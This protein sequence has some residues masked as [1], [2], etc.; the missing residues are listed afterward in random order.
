MEELTWRCKAF[1]D[2]TQDELYAILKLRS[3]VF[4]VEQECAYLD[5]DGDDQAAWHVLGEAE[6]NLL[7]Y[8]RLLPPGLKYDCCSIGRVVTSSKIRR[9]GIGR[10]LMERSI[11][12]CRQQWPDQ[13][14]TI[15]AQQYLEHFYQSLHFVTESDAYLEDGIPHVRMHLPYSPT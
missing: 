15:S 13:G 9:D 11:A 5:P 1:Y 3:E 2:L 12:Y 10:I 8:T 7:A 6:G 14:V 4:I